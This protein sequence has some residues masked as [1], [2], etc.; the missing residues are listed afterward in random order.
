MTVPDFIF[1]SYRRQCIY[2]ISYEAS[3]TEHFGDILWCN[4]IEGELFWY[5]LNS[6]YCILKHLDYITIVKL[7]HIYGKTVFINEVPNIEDL[8]LDESNI[9]D[10]VKG[11]NEKGFNAL[12]DLINKCYE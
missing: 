9:N 4:T 10:E 5:I 8:Y 2:P 7:Y 11:L 6:S 3:D 12:C 1:E